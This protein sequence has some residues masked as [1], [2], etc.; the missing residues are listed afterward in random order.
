MLVLRSPRLLLRDFTLEDWQD[1]HAYASRPEVCRFQAWGPNTPEESRAYVEGV[2]AL[3]QARPR[4]G[5][6]LAVVFPSTGTVIGAGGLDIRSQRFR[7]GEISYI[8]HPE[9]WKRGFATEVAHTL[10]TL[11]FT[12][13][14]LH[15]ICATCAPRNLASEH[16]LQKLGMRYEG[17]MRETMFIRD[18]WR[19]S[20]LYSLL[21]HEWQLEMPE[22]RAI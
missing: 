7:I 1:V 4:T 18:G 6:H 2:V 22:S 19:D 11:G 10:L 9:Y 8:I 16:V 3:A 13:L 12:S 17:R 21:E 14:S 5:F 20:L 15:R